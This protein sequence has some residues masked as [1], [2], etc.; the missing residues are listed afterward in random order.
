MSEPFGQLRPDVPHYDSMTPPDAVNGADPSN[1]RREWTEEK[2]GR[3]R[4]VRALANLTEVRDLLRRFNYFRNEERT[5]PSR[6]RKSVLKLSCIVCRELK[7]KC[8]TDKEGVGPCTRCVARG[9]DCVF[10]KHRRTQKRDTDRIEDIEQSF[11]VVYKAFSELVSSASRC[12]LADLEQSAVDAK[13]PKRASHLGEDG[14]SSCSMSPVGNSRLAPP[15]RSAIE[16][17]SRTGSPPRRKRRVDPPSV[18]TG[19]W[20][21][22][23]LTNSEDEAGVT[24]NPLKLLAASAVDP[25]QRG[26]QPLERASSPVQTS[27]PPRWRSTPHKVLDAGAYWRK[28]HFQPVPDIG[29]QAVSVIDAGIISEAQAS[30]YLHMFFEGR[31]KQL[32]L[33]DPYLHTIHYLR[34]HSSM[35]L[36]VICSLEARFTE[37]DEDVALAMRRHIQ[38]KC[39]AQVMLPPSFKSLEL[40]QSFL[41]LVAYGSTTELAQHDRSWT[42]LYSAMCMATELGCHVKPLSKYTTDTSETHLRGL[43]NQE[44]F[45]LAVWMAERVLCAQTG[46]PSLMPKQPYEN[47]SMSSW[48]RQLYALPEDATMIA[49]IELE[50][51]VTH[52]QQLYQNLVADAQQDVAVRLQFY[53]DAFCSELSKWKTHYATRPTPE[54][55][56]AL[57]SARMLLC[58]LPIRDRRKEHSHF[59]PLQCR[60]LRNECRLAA[61]EF[62]EACAAQPVG[63][64]V[65]ATNQY[66]IAS[67]HATV[68]LVQFASRPQSPALPDA[69]AG[70]RAIEKVRLFTEKL[71]MSSKQPISRSWHSFA[72]TYVQLLQRVL[73]RTSDVTGA[74]A[75]LPNGKGS[76]VLPN[77]N[78]SGLRPPLLSRTSPS[79]RND[80]RSPMP[81]SLGFGSNAPLPRLGLAADGPNRSTWSEPVTGYILPAPANP[82][83]QPTDI[84]WPNTVPTTSAMDWSEADRAGPLMLDNLMDQLL[85]ASGVIAPDG[86]NEQMHLYVDQLIFGKRPTGA[87]SFGVGP[88]QQ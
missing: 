13:P 27:L 41:I 16:A 60:E 29:S 86:D 59:G 31:N 56:Q 61:M 44:R 58:S 21:G 22:D 82:I 28:S 68:M 30:K 57:S 62:I 85:S 50:I 81:G 33:L 84:G 39:M 15:D 52:H 73:S 74:S 42:F 38:E 71:L 48:H 46:R 40:G 26:E 47:E 49:N 75:F 25:H 9:D 88:P 36:G 1:M 24:V 72:A 76:V 80:S 87:P 77:P 69:Y 37:G 78:F 53:R 20:P 19:N 11:D 7:V 63:H 43:R 23:D 65:Y 2:E 32:Q 51:T 83:G 64:L 8:Q 3:E 6:G 55:V 5:K 45:W 17:P 18:Q 35:L 4:L 79:L 14:H 54:Q 10:E 34:R 12:S 66:I 67:V 70:Q